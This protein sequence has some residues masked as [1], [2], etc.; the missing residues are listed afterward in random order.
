MLLIFNSATFTLPNFYSDFLLSSFIKKISI[1]CIKAKEHQA[2]SSFKLCGNKT[3]DDFGAFS[4][5][6]LFCW[7]VTW[8]NS[9]YV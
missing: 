2:S 5:V 9:S 3:E 1:W 8:D 4:L 6:H 7:I